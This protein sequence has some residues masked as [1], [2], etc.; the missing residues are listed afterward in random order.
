MGALCCA[1]PEAE[2]VMES[3]VFGDAKAK[4]SWLCIPE[5]FNKKESIRSI[6]HRTRKYVEGFQI[7]W[8]QND[9]N[10]SIE[11]YCDS[12]VGLCQVIDFDGILLSHVEMGF[13][14]EK[15]SKT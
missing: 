3:R 7:V 13:A 11:D 1:E 4:G 5:E 14:K 15:G 6:R 10:E 2:E 12:Q 8:G 9:E